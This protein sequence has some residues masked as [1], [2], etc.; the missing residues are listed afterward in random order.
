MDIYEALKKH[1]EIKEEE[2]IWAKERIKELEE[3]E[4]ALE[5][6][7]KKSKSIHEILRNKIAIKE[8][9]ASHFED[10]KVCTSQRTTE[11]CIDANIQN[12]FNNNSTII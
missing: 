9:E 11:T 6:F 10:E 8:L 3:N 7:W 1:M 4:C 5:K 2:L 12:K